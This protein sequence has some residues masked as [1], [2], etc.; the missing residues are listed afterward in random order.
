MKNRDMDYVKIIPAKRQLRHQRLEF[1]GFFHFSINTFTDKEWGDGSE[2]PWI[3]NPEQMDARQWAKIIK[4]AGMTGAILTCKHH[5]GFCLW[6]SQ[7]TDHTI[8]A[9]PYKNGKGDIVREVSEA[10][11]EQELKFGI[12]LSPWD[13]NNQAYGQ[14]KIYDDY[15][16][17]QLEELLTQY[18]PVFTVWLDGACGENKEGKRQIYDWER[19]YEVIRRLA[20]DACISV[21]GPDVRWCGNEAGE[22]RET[23]WSVVPKRLSDAEKVA[24]A[25]QKENNDLF[26]KQR[27]K[28]DDIDLGSR[29]K[30]EAEKELI[31][32]PS[33]VNTSIRPG[34]FYHEAEDDQVKSLQTLIHIYE[35]SVGGN[36]TF[37]LNIPP[38]K[39]GVI[40]P[41]DAA[42]LGEL[43]E[44][45]K[46][47]YSENL[48]SDAKIFINDYGNNIDIS[49]KDSKGCLYH[50][51]EGETTLDL[52][53]S[54]PEEKSISK[55]VLMEK[56]EYSQRIERF[57]IW[58]KV[59]QRYKLIYEG[60]TVGYKKIASFDS[61]QTD[62]IKIQILDSR[63]SI[64][65]N[66]LGLY[67]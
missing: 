59:K 21:C 48:M 3:F 33:E 20:P 38:T 58:A 14:G 22:T 36:A 65:L 39:E 9:S 27:I 17:C 4:S 41:N 32:Y 31:W 15:F 26:R 57:C 55:A 24:E 61:I 19:Y 67:A 7:Y 40:H 45:L 56:I 51:K 23:E 6:P 66:Y 46:R 8:A 10:L 34:W 42:R 1:Y 44:Y 2:D 16:I 18:G 62:E 12:Y 25:S 53:I 37:L 60:T 64:Y 11:K 50:T 29:K 13:R 54:F 28:S 49:E 35:H 30:L 52:R 63:V 5:D 47:I 43:G